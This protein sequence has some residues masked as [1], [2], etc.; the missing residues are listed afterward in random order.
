MIIMMIMNL[1]MEKNLI[2]ENNE[3][4]MK[5]YVESLKTEREKFKEFFDH[6]RQ[7]AKSL[8]LPGHRPDADPHFVAAPAM[9]A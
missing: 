1:Y 7:I 8:P 3:Q 2:L 9:W 5:G 4:A 6:R